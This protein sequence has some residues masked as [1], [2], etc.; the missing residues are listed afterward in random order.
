MREINGKTVGVLD[1]SKRRRDAMVED[2]EL[3]DLLRA[4]LSARLAPTPPPEDQDVFPG[5]PAAAE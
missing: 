5:D 4:R 3:R 2:P 1:R